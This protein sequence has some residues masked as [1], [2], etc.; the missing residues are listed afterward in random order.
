[1][2][3]YVIIVLLLCVSLKPE[4]QESRSFKQTIR[5]VV[6]DEDTKSPL[7]GTN[8]IIQNSDPILGTVT[9]TDGKFK[10]ENVPV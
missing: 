10:I 8:L 2:K 1:M 7:I 6:I 5:G 4:A 3:Y 9:D